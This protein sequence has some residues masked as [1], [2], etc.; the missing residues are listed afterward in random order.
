MFLCECH[1]AQPWHQD[2]E[3]HALESQLAE[4]GRVELRDFFWSLGATPLSEWDNRDLR[5]SSGT[6][7]L[8]TAH[9]AWPR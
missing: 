7:T 5:D 4:D 2:K 9:A 6:P 8:S 1:L 3:A